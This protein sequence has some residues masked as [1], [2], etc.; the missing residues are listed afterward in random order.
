MAAGH[1]QRHLP[2][3]VRL[4]PD[5]ESPARFRKEEGGKKLGS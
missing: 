1:I 5:D 4:Y 2:D 3:A